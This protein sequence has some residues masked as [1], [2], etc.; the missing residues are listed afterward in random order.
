MAT[1]MKVDEDTFE[2]RNEKDYCG[3]TTLIND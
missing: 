3:D 2:L 1:K